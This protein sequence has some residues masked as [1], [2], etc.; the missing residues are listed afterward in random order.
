M[1]SHEIASN[2]FPYVGLD[3]VPKRAKE[4]G[5]L[6]IR[7]LEKP[8]LHAVGGVAGLH[9]QISKTG[10]RSWILRTMVGDRR[11]DIGVGAFPDIPL[12][13]ARDRARAIKADIQNGI[14]PVLQRAANRSALMREQS[15]AVTFEQQARLY[16]ERKGKE[17]KAG[18]K[19][20]QKLTGHMERYA[21]PHIGSM[22]VADIEMADIVRM[23]LPIWESKTETAVRVRLAVE[24]ILDS[25]IA[26]GKRKAANPARWKGLLEHSEL[27]AAG[28]VS[29]TVHHAALPVADMPAFW[30]SLQQANGMGARVLQFII[31]TACR[32]GEARG[33]TWAEIDLAAKTWTIPAER[34]KAGRAHVV[35]LCDAAVALLEQTPRMSQYLFTG[36]RGAQISDVMV[37]K[38]PKTLGHDVT[39]HGFR[40]TFK[41]W[42]RTRTNYADEVSELALAHVNSDSVR[43]AYARDGLIDKR[44]ALMTDWARFLSEPAPRGNVV[45]ILEAR[46]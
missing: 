46:G 40:S 34:M 5:S 18:T 24:K 39:A 15:K 10:S 13:M 4:F 1:L 30:G 16:M 28:R 33:A 7:R 44:R 12:A 3:V 29:R 43:A 36:G 27:P 23:L 19:Q 20:L 8:G 45:G 35:P 37:S 2:H 31:L 6:E 14:D 26:S 11:R 38:V 22:L 17:F 42:C 25:A 41:D 32:S 21:F 9:L